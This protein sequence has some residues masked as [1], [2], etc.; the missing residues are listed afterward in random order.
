MAKIPENVSTETMRYKRPRLSAADEDAP[1]TTYE[2]LA[3]VLADSEK[4]PDVLI[5]FD[6]TLAKLVAS[7]RKL[8]SSKFEKAFTRL[9]VL[10]GATMVLGAKPM[11]FDVPSPATW[12]KVRELAKQCPNKELLA[13]EVDRNSNKTSTP[14]ELLT[15]W[16]DL[17]ANG[18]G[19][20]PAMPIPDLRAVPDD[21]ALLLVEAIYT[22]ANVLAGMTRPEDKLYSQEDIDR[23]YQVVDE[24]RSFNNS[25]WS[26]RMDMLK[27]LVD[28]MRGSA[29]FQCAMRA[30]GEARPFKR[31]DDRE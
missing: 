5:D 21:L 27:M 9:M 17:K 28:T 24:I 8:Q 7:V 1:I 22:Q 10:A 4:P 6:V 25:H 30:P 3:A 15:K 19:P 13:Q 18:Q 20:M 2:Q 23:F 31:C 12:S 11:A 29:P 14:A 26:A 16:R